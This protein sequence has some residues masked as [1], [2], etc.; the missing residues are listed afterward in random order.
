[1]RNKKIKIPLSKDQRK[2]LEKGIVEMVCSRV[3]LD[4][5]SALRVALEENEKLKKDNRRMEMAIS[6]YMKWYALHGT[7]K[8]T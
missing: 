4:L 5:D 3:V 6:T 7:H 1:M 2:A 8:T